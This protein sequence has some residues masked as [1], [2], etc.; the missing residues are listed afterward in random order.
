MQ[1]SLTLSTLALQCLPQTSYHCS[2]THFYSRPYY[3]VLGFV[4]EFELSKNSS[5]LIC[6]QYILPKF[7]DFSLG[8]LPWISEPIQIFHNCWIALV[9]PLGILEIE[10]LKCKN[11]DQKSFFLILSYSSLSSIITPELNLYQFDSVY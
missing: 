4:C 1:C 2:N 5:N 9:F 8:L 3:S 11:L 10:K 7:L 6:L